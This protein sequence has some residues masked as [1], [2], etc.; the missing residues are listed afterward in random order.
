MIYVAL[1]CLVK[2]YMFVSF[3]F[4]RTYFILGLWALAS[5]YKQIYN[6]IELNAYVKGDIAL[7][8]CSY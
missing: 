6:L 4:S 3:L 2:V 1:F 7:M 8:H 5:V